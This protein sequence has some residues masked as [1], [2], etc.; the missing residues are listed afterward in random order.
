MFKER[1]IQKDKVQS[2]KEWKNTK[3]YKNTKCVSGSNGKIQKKMYV[4]LYLL[5]IL[6][7]FVK[8]QNNYK[9]YKIN[10]NAIS[11]KYKIQKN[12]NQ[13]FQ[14]YKIQTKKY[15]PK[16]SKIQNTKNTN[17]TMGQRANPMFILK[18]KNQ[19]VK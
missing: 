13:K 15:E 3:K 7:F 11:Q 18:S 2:V 12:T 5:C 16:I 8:I 10:T 6:S 17:S 14:K 4:F 19:L 9:K 1:K